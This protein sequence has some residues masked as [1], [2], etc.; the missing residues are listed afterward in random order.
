MKIKRNLE[1]DE[2][3]CSS[4]EKFLRWVEASVE[5]NFAEFEKHLLSG[6]LDVADRNKLL[7]VLFEIAPPKMVITLVPFLLNILP[8]RTIYFRFL[9]IAV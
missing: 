4:N 9:F 1:Q 6:S 5:V 2:V 8:F 3:A 7:D